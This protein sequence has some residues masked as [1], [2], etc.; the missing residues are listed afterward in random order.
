MIKSQRR[1]IKTWKVR[2]R[3]WI[4][5]LRSNSLGRSDKE[6]SPRMK[7]ERDESS[8]S[9]LNLRKILRVKGIE[10]RGKRSPNPNDESRKVLIRKIKI[11]RVKKGGL[12]TLKRIRRD[13]KR[14]RMTQRKRSRK[15]R[16]NEE[17]KNKLNLESETRTYATSRQ[18]NLA[19]RTASEIATQISTDMNQ[20]S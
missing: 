19:M 13:W 8:K 18:K 6:K 10:T 3:K 20:T 15:N 12:W 14:L 16:K 4:L 11:M 5:T 7:S 1:S 2:W 9:R 17:G